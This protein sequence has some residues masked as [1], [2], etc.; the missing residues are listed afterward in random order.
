MRSEVPF[1]LPVLIAQVTD[2]ASA[3]IHGLELLV[4]LEVAAQGA[5]VGRLG[6]LRHPELAAVGAR[7]SVAAVE[8]VPRHHVA[9][10]LHAGDAFRGLQRGKL[11]P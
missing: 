4:S 2:L 5:P 8:L 9:P 11:G 1:T 10:L 7:D 3:Q 6:L